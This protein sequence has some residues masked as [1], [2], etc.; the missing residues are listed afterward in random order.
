MEPLKSQVTVIITTSAIPSN[1][2][3]AV[4][5]EVLRSF[6]FVPDLNTCD[7][8]LT[9]DGFAVK[10]K[11]GESK[12]K[13][14]KIT[15][16]EAENYGEYIQRARAVFR[17]HLDFAETETVSS[18]STTSTVP[19]GARAT[20]ESTVTRDSVVGKPTFSMITLSKRL[21]FALAV[22]EALKLVSTPYILIHQ[23]DWTYLHQ[24]DFSVLCQL[25]DE[26]PE[27]LQ[28]IGFSTR[29][30]LRR[31]CRPFLPRAVP[32][33]F[34]S[35]LLS[36][37]YFWYDKPH[38]A[39]ASH[40]RTFLFGHGR[41]RVGDFIEDTMGQSMLADLKARGVAAHTAYGTWSYVRPDDP[42]K[43]TLR[44][45]SGRHFRETVY[46]RTARHSKKNMTKAMENL[47]IDRKDDDEEN[48]SSDDD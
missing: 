39:R 21:G 31:K 33:E 16:Q 5:E 9:S 12:F 28:Y 20:A 46:M 42:E 24:L 37:L 10:T 40:Y 25:M 29:K 11:P 7:V 17:K 44:H 27:E 47:S 36:P 45:R 34:G 22:R 18:T 8:V 4:L 19:I 6:S 41:F 1:P 35:V 38:L 43:P 15:E 26:H 2:S 13:S 32:R 23:H 30:S 14:I 3:T 48:D